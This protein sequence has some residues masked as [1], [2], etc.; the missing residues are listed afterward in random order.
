MCRKWQHFAPFARLWR[1]TRQH[2]GPEKAEVF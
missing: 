1:R 2:K